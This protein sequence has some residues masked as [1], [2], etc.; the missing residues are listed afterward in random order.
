MKVISQIKNLDV[1]KILKDTGSILEGHFKLSS[2]YHSKYYLQCASLLQYPDKISNI[3][4]SALEIIDK[5]IKKNIIQTVVSPAIGGIL[6][7]Y[8]LA[9]KLKTRMIFT[10]RKKGKM[11]LRRNFNI[12]PGENIL[13]AEDV[14]TTGG[15]VFEVIDICRKF[16]ANIKGI[17]SIVDRSEKIKFNYPY[18]YL[19]KLK[20]ENY[21]PSECPLCKKNIEFDYPGS[22]K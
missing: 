18:F 10:E 1:L 17:I 20:I 12:I 15:S 13:I 4:D 14:I 6:F 8:L 9:Y 22:R 21:L 19:I 5:E 16:G 11:E 7:G 3:I 2:G